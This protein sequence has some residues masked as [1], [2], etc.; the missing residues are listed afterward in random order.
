[1][2]ANVITLPHSFTAAIKE[3]ATTAQASTVDA[4]ALKYGFDAEEA[5]QFLASLD[6]KIVK[7]RG[8]VAK[9]KPKI[10]RTPKDAAVK[11]KTKRAPTG[12]LLFSEQLRSEVRQELSVEL[13]EGEKLKPQLVVKELAKRWAALEDDERQVWRDHSALIA[14][15]PILELDADMTESDGDAE[16]DI[17]IVREE[18]MGSGD[19]SW[20]ECRLPSEAPRC[21]HT[22]QCSCGW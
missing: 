4:L 19:P 14:A 20:N 21:N 2:T 8:P 3:V 10:K 5:H 18:T 7:K 22:G 13:E 1:M 16:V 6:I 12:Y 15:V 17:V 9:T 11:P